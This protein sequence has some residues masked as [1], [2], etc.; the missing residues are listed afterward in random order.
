MAGKKRRP[1]ISLDDPRLLKVAELAKDV[2]RALLKGG[3]QE[4]CHCKMCIASRLLLSVLGVLGEVEAELVEE[5]RQRKADQGD[6]AVTEI[7]AKGKSDAALED[8]TR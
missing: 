5:K 2:R 7:Q 3:H 8:E 1:K 6:R 4:S